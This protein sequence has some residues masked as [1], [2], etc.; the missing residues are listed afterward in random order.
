[1]NADL[2]KE[3]CTQSLLH[4]SMDFFPLLFQATLRT[5]LNTTFH[6]DIQRKLHLCCG[7]PDSIFERMQFLC[8]ADR[9]EVAD[10]HQ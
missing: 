4:C 10:K 1:M 3:Q 8:H 2:L 7:N 6:H 9:D 5:F